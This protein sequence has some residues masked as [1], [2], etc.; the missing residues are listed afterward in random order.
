MAWQ[1]F[2]AAT[3]TGDFL[4]DWAWAEVAA[5]DGEPPHRYLLEEDG[6]IVAI[7]AAQ[8]RSLPLGRTFWYVPHGP[9]ID[10]ANPRAAE[11][12]KAL[13]VALRVVAAEHRA[14]RRQARAAGGGRQCARGAVPSRAWPS[15]D[16]GDA[17]GGPDP[18]RRSHRR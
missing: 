8:P 6:S 9:V 15:T 14:D 2:L 18:H 5:H 1:A 7:V 11:R 3:S 13:V 10:L 16:G 12:L 17:P 4:H